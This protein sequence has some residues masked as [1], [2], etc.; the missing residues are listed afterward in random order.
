MISDKL[1]TAPGTRNSRQAVAARQAAWR[2]SNARR[3]TIRPALAL[4]RS[5]PRCPGRPA[6]PQAS[7]QAKAGSGLPASGN[8]LARRADLLWAA[9]LQEAW[10]VAYSDFAERKPSRIVANRHAG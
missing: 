6:L 3:H 4:R 10:C 2:S 5:Q 8:A 9:D 1:L 7:A